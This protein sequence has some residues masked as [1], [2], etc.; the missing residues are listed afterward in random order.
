MEEF[1]VNS[2]DNRGQNLELVIFQTGGGPILGFP[3]FQTEH[4]RLAG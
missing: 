4:P 2:K 3:Y 1:R